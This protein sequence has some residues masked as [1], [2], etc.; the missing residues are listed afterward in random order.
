MLHSI[1]SSETGVHQKTLNRLVRF[2]DQFKQMNFVNDRVMEEQLERV[3]RELLTKTAEEY[4]DSKTA[5]NRLVQGLSQL[6]NHAQQL[7]NQDATELVQRFGE[8]G[9]KEVPLGRMKT[10]IT[11]RLCEPGWWDAERK[12]RYAGWSVA[13]QITKKGRGWYCFNDAINKMIGPFKTSIGAKRACP[14]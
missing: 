12:G 11:W 2:I 14:V 4:R 13:R 5:R 10:R 1:N 8:M 6:A 9:Q 7:A 3:R